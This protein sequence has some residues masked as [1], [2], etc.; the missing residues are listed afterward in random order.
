MLRGEL[1]QVA[2]EQRMLRKDGSML[3]VNRT[4]VLVRTASGEP[5][6][7]IG[8]YEDITDRKAAETALAHE[9]NLLRSVVDTVPDSLF[10]KD[11]EGR[12]LLLNRFA[13]KIRGIRDLSEGLGRKVGDFHS[14]E[15][16][17][18]LED[19]DR[20]VLAG[21]DPIVNHERM[22]MIDGGQHYMLRTKVPLRDANGKIIGLIGIARDVTERKA[23]ETVLRDYS[24]RLQVLSRR[25]IDAQERERAVIARELHDQTGQVLSVLKLTLQLA[26]RDARA[27]QV[28]PHLD[29]ALQHIDTALQQVRTLSYSLR[30]PQLDDLGLVAAL[31]NYADRI[32][33]VGGL[34]LHYEIQ[35]PP[36]L[37]GQVAIACFR[38]AQEAITNVIR[39]AAA[40]NLWIAL[41]CDDELR[42]EVRDDGRG[43]DMLEMRRRALRG[44]SMGVVN[45]EERTLLG[46]G[47]IDIDSSP[48][49]GMAVRATFPFSDTEA[50]PTAGR[51]A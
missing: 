49:N 11:R 44:D 5:R 26:R 23:A 41:A 33:G 2:G 4:V 12:Y 1:E 22:W 27:R 45:M 20:Q 24:E 25:L 28:A 50:A 15:L 19:E 13:M 37:A 9:R 36:R 3:W 18:P 38:V 21:G 47:R 32:A 34:N 35:A 8:V 16:A 40:K 29:E 10:V 48:G 14:A 39:H 31:R 43:C 30:P 46:G 6:H 42:L 51:A 7:F 17:A